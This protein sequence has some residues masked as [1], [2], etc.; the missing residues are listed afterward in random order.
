MEIKPRDVRRFCTAPPADLTVILLFGNDRGLI[1]ERAGK[2]AA[3]WVGPD[4]DPMSTVSLT[5][6]EIKEDPARLGD[7]AGSFSMFGGRQAIRVAD[8][9]KGMA[10]LVIPLMEE[11]PGDNLVILEGHG[12]SKSDALPKAVIKARS[13]AAIGCYEDL[14]RDLGSLVQEVLTEADLNVR[15]DAMAGLMDRLGEDRA[16][17]RQALGTLVLYKGKDTSPINLEDVASALGPAEGAGLSDL[18]DCVSA[19]D[20]VGAIRAW[21]ACVKS[22]TVAGSATRALSNH[23]AMLLQIKLS[24]DRGENADQVA[25]RHRLHFTR[26]DGVMRAARNW[27]SEALESASENILQAELDTRRHAVLAPVFVER[28]LLNLCRLAPRR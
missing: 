9:D 19:G 14:S 23:F 10:K 5:G 25:R 2:I 28:A 11:T 26:K 27:R 24:M 1:R 18:A 8:S 15:P 6:A 12:M 21:G 16:L 13:G 22:G 17:S 3:V 4:A 20:T 7:A